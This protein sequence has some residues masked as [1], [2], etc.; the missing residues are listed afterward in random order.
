MS[1]NGTAIHLEQTNKEIGQEF[2]SNSNPFKIN[3]HTSN[4]RNWLNF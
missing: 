3:K 4:L 1:S 2:Q